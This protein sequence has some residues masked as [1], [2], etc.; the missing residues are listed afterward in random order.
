MESGIGLPCFDCRYVAF[1]LVLNTQL[2]PTWLLYMIYRMLR[3]AT[4]VFFPNTASFIFLWSRL[5]L[6]KKKFQETH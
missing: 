2:K 1:I 3:Q 6:P 5:I 4:E